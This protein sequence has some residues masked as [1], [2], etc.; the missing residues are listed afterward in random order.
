MSVNNPTSGTNG[1]NKYD[2]STAIG[3]VPEELRVA[4][5][6]VSFLNSSGKP[7]SWKYQGGSWAVASFIKE[8]DGGNK[9]LT[10]VTDAATT[11][12]Q[13]GANERKAGMQISYK[14][15][16][17]DWVNEQ[18][19]GT[20][21]T[22]TEWAKD[23]NW[24]KIPK[25]SEVTELSGKIGDILGTE[26]E[27][28]YENLELSSGQTFYLPTDIYDSTLVQISLLTNGLTQTIFQAF[29]ESGET[30]SFSLKP[31]FPVSI[32]I[33]NVKELYTLSKEQI[34]YH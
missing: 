10:W 12:K 19:V 13:V 26:E 17:E 15:D 6:K 29:S 31:N 33:N 34:R 32:F 28:L 16:G 2:L 8:A 1:G 11:R 3:Q 27:T 14:P 21:F 9:I 18:Y 30:L 23:A 24:E 20:S 7:E 25:Q 5:M 4:G 22:D